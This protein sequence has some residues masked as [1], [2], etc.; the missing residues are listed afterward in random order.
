MR[1][2]AVM[3][4]GYTPQ[5]R[6]KLSYSNIKR[7]NAHTRCSAILMK[8]STSRKRDNVPDIRYIVMQV[9]NTQ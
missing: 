8:R 6:Q 4:W 3:V 2:L 1:L 7:S 9:T 5:A